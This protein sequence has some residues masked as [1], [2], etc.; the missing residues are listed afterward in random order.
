MYDEIYGHFEE[1]VKP[2][3]TVWASGDIV[4]PTRKIVVGESRE[5]RTGYTRHSYEAVNAFWNKLYFDNYK[6][7]E[8]KRKDYCCGYTD[9]LL[10]M[11]RR[12]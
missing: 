6:D 4:D 12:R 7:A 11:Q 8:R 10:E 3:D 2:G 5:R 1:H 9:W